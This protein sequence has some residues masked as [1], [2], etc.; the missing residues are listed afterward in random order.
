VEKT[1]DLLQVIDKLYHIMLYTSP[2]SRFKLTIS[3][4]ICTDCIG[5]GKSNWHTITATSPHQKINQSGIFIRGVMWPWSYGS[6]IYHYL[7]NQCISPLIL[8]V[9]IS[10]RARCTTLCD[11]VC[12]WLATGLWFSPQLP[13]DHG[14]MTPLMNMPDWLIF[15]C[16][17]P[18][19]AIFQLYHAD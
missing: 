17:M 2:W 7:C 15:W 5:S 18:L 9:W 8:W 13:Y 12:Q 4:V 10:I 14:H 6:W 1:T 3:V 16:F 19:S 11:K